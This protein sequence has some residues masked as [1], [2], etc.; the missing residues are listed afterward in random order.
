MRA[1][2]EGPAYSTKAAL[3]VIT[4]LLTILKVGPARP[5]A[6]ATLGRRLQSVGPHDVK[7]FIPACNGDLPIRSYAGQERC[8]VGVD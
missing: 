8:V 1:D 2:C 5:P 7:G 6:A 4:I 3:P